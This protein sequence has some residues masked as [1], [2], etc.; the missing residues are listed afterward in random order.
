MTRMLHRC[1]AVSA[2]LL[3]LAGCGRSSSPGQGG[4]SPAAAASTSGPNGVHVRTKAYAIDITYPPLSPQADGLT[5]LLHQRAAAVRGDFMKAV[6]DAGRAPVEDGHTRRLILEFEVASR[7]PGFLSVRE[8]G[9]MDT[10]GAHPTPLIDTY[11][12]DL[13]AGKRV[14]LDDLFTDPSGM[15]ATLAAYARKALYAQ[16]LDK[17]PGGDK[18]SPKVRAQWQANMRGMIDPGTEPTAKH[19]RRFLIGGGGLDRPLHL[20]LVFPPYQVAPYVYGVQTVD[21]PLKVFAGGLK[22]AYRPAF[23]LAP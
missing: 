18:T 5:R 21:V 6:A 22:P 4:T 10:G 20:T 15:R 1:L 17:V 8:K 19:F 7:T 2:T 12:F 13:R 9:L 14:M 23:G 16:L 11:V 3:L